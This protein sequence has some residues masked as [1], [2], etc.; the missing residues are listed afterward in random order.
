MKTPDNKL[1]QA[2][3]GPEISVKEAVIFAA[4]VVV[5]LSVLG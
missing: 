2:I 5:L 3:F 4:A 1:L